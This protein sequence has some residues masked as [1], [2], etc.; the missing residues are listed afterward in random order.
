MRA[1]EEFSECR[2]VTAAIHGNCGV[3]CFVLREATFST[4]S[5]SHASAEPTHPSSSCS[6]S[7]SLGGRNDILRHIALRTVM[8]LI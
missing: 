1:C 2:G 3:T 6:S 4:Q 7:A 8:E 5:L